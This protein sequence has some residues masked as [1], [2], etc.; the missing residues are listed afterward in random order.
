MGNLSQHFDRS[1]FACQCGCGYDTADYELVGIL[2]R[3][4]S[5]WGQPI[6]INS[7]CRCEQHN[8]KI[9][10]SP[11]SQHRLGRAADIV[12]KGKNPHQVYR[13]LEEW[14]PNRYG[15]GSYNTFTHVDTRGKRARWKG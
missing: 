11:R 3:L 2:E 9:G 7:G 6:K 13:Q 10:G 12:V 5:H 15:I 8:K 1:E 14:Y 4:R